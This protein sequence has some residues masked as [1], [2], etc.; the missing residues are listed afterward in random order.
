M[1]L[2]LFPVRNFR[3]A[4]DKSAA[5]RYCCFQFVTFALLTTNQPQGASP[6]CSGYQAQGL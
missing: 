5:G 1:A 4:D 6:G 2:L 3:A